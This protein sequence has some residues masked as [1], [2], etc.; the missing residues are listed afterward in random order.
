MRG[1]VH[2]GGVVYCAV[3]E[4]LRDLENVAEGDWERV[5]GLTHD[6]IDKFRPHF[7]IAK[8]QDYALAC[9]LTTRKHRGAEGD[10]SAEWE[11]LY[12]LA[13]PAE[14][15]AEYPFGETF[16]A[17]WKGMAR[18]TWIYLQPTR[19]YYQD[20]LAPIDGA[21]AADQSVINFCSRLEA[22]ASDIAAELLKARGL[23]KDQTED[24][25][26][27]LPGRSRR[28]SERMSRLDGR[29]SPDDLFAGPHLDG[30]WRSQGYRQD[31]EDDRSIGGQ[32]LGAR[33]VRQRL[34]ELERLTKETEDNY[35]I[36]EE[37]AEADHQV[38]KQRMEARHKL[39]EEGL[40]AHRK[41]EKERM[42]AERGRTMKETEA[43]IERLKK[44]VNPA[45]RAEEGKPRRTYVDPDRVDSGI[46]GRHA[47]DQ[48]A[49]ASYVRNP[50]SYADVNIPQPARMPMTF[51]E[52]DDTTNRKRKHGRVDAAGPRTDESHHHPGE[53][54]RLE[55]SSISPNGHP[56]KKVK[57]TAAGRGVAAG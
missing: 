20:W 12:I 44:L 45:H 43:E 40:E 10:F 11:A 14:L 55:E 34:A 42:E 25:T 56:A 39:E 4:V 19:V 37:R 57:T 33:G 54:V 49:S 26:T 30:T 32:F 51:V 9:P 5:K 21:E 36:E 18:E 28:L 52:K 13:H 31:P 47:P 29:L 46:R 6:L 3:P 16:V 22:Q 24:L 38:E 1:N 17:C 7:I 50:I 2:R 53:R 23:E 41:V 8:Y 27:P 48:N 15:K 35:Q